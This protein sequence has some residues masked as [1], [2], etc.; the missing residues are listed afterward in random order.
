MKEIKSMQC[1]ILL[2]LDN[3]KL[4]LLLGAVHWLLGHARYPVLDGIRD[5]RN[6]LQ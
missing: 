2:N 3:A 5:M 6:N 1:H 4:G